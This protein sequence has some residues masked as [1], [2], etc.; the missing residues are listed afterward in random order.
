MPD[1]LLSHTKSAFGFMSHFDGDAWAEAGVL[2][3]GTDRDAHSAGVDDVEGLLSKDVQQA[4]SQQRP[5]SARVN[6]LKMSV[7]QVLRWLSSPP[8]NYSSHA[9]KVCEP[10]HKTASMSFPA[11]LP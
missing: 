9:H 1:L 8:P 6:T 11:I 4:H 10:L 7:A 3:Q 2:H 5:R